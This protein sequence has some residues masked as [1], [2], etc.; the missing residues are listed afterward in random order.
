MKVKVCQ[1]DE[2]LGVLL[3]DE[4]I[5]SLGWEPGDIIQ[6]QLENGGLRMARVQTAFENGME[7]AEVL[8]NEYRDTLQ[9]LAKE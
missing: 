2:E 7:V 9:A 6:V 5:L 8:M 4:L 1:F 3:P